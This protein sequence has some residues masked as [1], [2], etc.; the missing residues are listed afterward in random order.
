MALASHS[1]G[2]KFDMASAG[3]IM[4][5]LTTAVVKFQ[6]I[7]CRRRIMIAITRISPLLIVS[8]VRAPKFGSNDRSLV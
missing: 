2:N 6:M 1:H 5:R 7:F 3:A 4:I 8:L